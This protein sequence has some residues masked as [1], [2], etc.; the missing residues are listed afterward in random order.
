MTLKLSLVGLV[1]VLCFMLTVL[2]DP[3]LRMHVSI[4]LG[5]SVLL[6]IL[7]IWFVGE[8]QAAMIDQADSA[9]KK[10]E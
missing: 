7:V 2:E 4:F 1:L 8:L 5:M 3:T 10:K 9:D 6:L